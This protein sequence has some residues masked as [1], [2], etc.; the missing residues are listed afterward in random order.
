M[1]AELFGEASPCHAGRHHMVSN[2]IE[3]FCVEC[4]LVHQDPPVDER[5]AFG[6]PVSAPVPISSTIWTIGADGKGDRLSFDHR[7]HFLRLD[8]IQRHYRYYGGRSV[9]H[10][11]EFFETWGPVRSLLSFAVER[12]GLPSNP[13]EEARRV[14]DVSWHDLIGYAVPDRVAAALYVTLESGRWRVAVPMSEVVRVV[15]GADER[16][17]KIV[18]HILR[19]LP[20]VAKAHPALALYLPFYASRLGLTRDEAVRVKEILADDV[21]AP[22]NGHDMVGTIAAAVYCIATDWGRAPAP[23]HRTQAYISAIVS[24]S[25][26]TVRSAAREMR[27]RRVGK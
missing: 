19:R 14:L 8:W 17:T 4:G 2:S 9:Q 18:S 6:H 5:P 24:L 1:S 26:L 23:R 25:E 20:G 16:K 3:F 22:M 21:L 7:G 15:P 27:E 10:Q 13:A 11:R 12:L